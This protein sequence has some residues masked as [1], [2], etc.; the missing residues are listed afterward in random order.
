MIQLP[1]LDTYPRKMKTYVCRKTFPQMFLAVLLIRAKSCKQSCS[2]IKR[3]ES[4][5]HI[6]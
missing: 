5:I 2:I 6:T 3:D 1:L 4:L